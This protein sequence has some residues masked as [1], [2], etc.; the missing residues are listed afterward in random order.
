MVPKR[1]P[2]SYRRTNIL[3][4]CHLET[5]PAQTAGRQESTLLKSPLFEAKNRLFGPYKTAVIFAYF[6]EKMATGYLQNTGR[7]R[8]RGLHLLT[9][10]FF[11]RYYG[12][13]EFSIYNNELFA[14]VDEEIEQRGEETIHG[15]YLLTK[16]YRIL[17]NVTANVGTIS[18][19]DPEGDHQQFCF[20]RPSN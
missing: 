18:Y 6:L 8:M 13:M 10:L 19:D 2:V 7:K 15:L 17:P 12:D 14:N 9:I 3:E 4:G 5:R 11:P 16:R 20:W 1:S